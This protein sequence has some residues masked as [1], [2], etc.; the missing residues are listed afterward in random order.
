MSLNAAAK[1]AVADE[2][3]EVIGL[4]HRIHAAPELA[5][6]EH[7]AAR[8]VADVM[9]AHGFRVN[10]G[11]AGLPT[12]VTADYGRGD[13]VLGFCAEY[14]AAARNRSCVRS[15]HDRRGGDRC[16]AGPVGRR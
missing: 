7:W 12:A 6:A 16:R 10:R 8:G 9:A 4:S 3:A 1:Q 5:F 2:R 15:Q 14:D 13:L 11:V